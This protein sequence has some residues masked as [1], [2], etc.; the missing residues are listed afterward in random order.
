MGESSLVIC[1]NRKLTTVTFYKKLRHE[2]SSLYA[3]PPTHHHNSSVSTLS[4][5]LYNY[6]GDALPQQI[7]YQTEQRACFLCSILTP[8]YIFYDCYKNTEVA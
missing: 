2:A 4:A 5:L 1:A 6:D 7:T 8:I 3:P